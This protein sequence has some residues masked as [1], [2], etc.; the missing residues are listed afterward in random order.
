V[1]LVQSERRTTTLSQLR[2][3]LALVAVLAFGPATVGAQLIPAQDPALAPSWRDVSSIALVS[4]VASIQPGTPFTL[5]AHITADPG[6]HVYWI[7]GGDAGDELLVDWQ[8]PPG[9]TVGEFRFPA[10]HLVP[11]PPLMSYGY[12]GQ[13]FFLVEVTPPANLR[14]GTDVEIGGAADF[15]VCADTCLIALEDISVTLPVRAEAP[16]PDPSW[17]VSIADAATQIPTPAVGWS[18]RAWTNGLDGR[19]DA[20]FVIELRPNGEAATPPPA[21]LPAPHLFADEPLIIEHAAAQRVTR[22]GDAIRIEVRRNYFAA[23][24]S[25]RLSGLIV[26]DVDA[27]TAVAWSIDVPVAAQPPADVLA[28]G[29]DPFAEPGTLE[30]GGVPPGMAPLGRPEP[31]Q[32]TEVP[33]G[34][35]ATEVNLLLAFVFA[36]LGGA[37]LNLMPCVFP[38]LSMK[39]LGFVEQ[40]GEDPARARRHGFAFG[41]G[42]LVCFWIL[43]GTLMALRAG[44]QSLGW[45]FQ[46]QSPLIVGLLAM[47]L[48]GLGL[49]LS[50]LFELGVGLTRL[51]AVGTG[52]SYRDSFMMGGLTVLV[53]TPCTGPFMGAALGFALVQPALIGLGVFTALAVGLA[54]PYVLL[55]SSPSLLRRM[56][57]PG[58]WME[59][60]KQALAFPMYA[61]VV[62]LVWVFGNQAGVDSTA[63]LLFGLTFLAFA[64]WLYGRIGG[65]APSGR[66]R[67]SAAVI[68]LA[69]GAFVVQGARIAQASEASQEVAVGWETWSPERVA[70][71]RAE[72]RPIFIDFTADW[73]LQCKVNERIAIG[74][75]SVMTAFADANVALL[76]ADLTDRD[77]VITQ[78]LESFGRFGPPLYLLY[79]VDPDGE[80]EILPAILTS[81]I[82]IEAIGRATGQTPS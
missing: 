29:V 46:L 19:E 39:V 7:N 20:A 35:P 50:G 52:S 77:P 69:A 74:L 64:G 9:F 23:D 71:L 75:P 27:E 81:G 60:F 51:G 25:P 15:Q 32:I 16:A 65:H 17:G 28:E 21:S 26:A 66:V 63:L 5:A 22:V 6:W 14:A 42:V 72:G 53:A 8:L 49:N 82:I 61:T 73:C 31:V 10:P 36:L 47:L 18:Q 2:L 11:A 41:A 37:I 45:G 67:F 79:P 48:F 43:A 76:V 62:W 80:P 13:V 12:D 59:T 24:Y 78:E 58:A 68:A 4:S 30:T 33:R 56:P 34:E 38:V 54:A 1:R 55:S 70:V 3:G 40:G 57:R 44:G